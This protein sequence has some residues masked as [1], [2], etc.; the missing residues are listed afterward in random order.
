MKID[1]EMLTQFT[2]KLR[3]KF[4]SGKF[5]VNGTEIKTIHEY[6][7]N[8]FYELFKVFP[9]DSNMKYILQSL[10]NLPGIDH[11]QNWPETKIVKLAKAAIESKEDVGPLPIALDRKKLIILNIL[12]YRPGEEVMFITTGPG[13][14]GKSTFLNLIKQL[15]DNDVSG[16]SLS[17]LGNSFDLAEALHHRLIASDELDS[18]ELDLKV[19]KTIISHQKIQLNPKFERPYTTRAQSQL[20]YCCN[21]VPRIDI[22]D[23]GILRRI[24]YYEMPVVIKNPNTS[25]NHQVFTDE[26]LLAV[27]VAAYNV[28]MTNWKKEFEKETFEYL[29]KNNSVQIWKNNT[30]IIVW[31]E[32]F[33]TNYYQNYKE[34][35]F[36]CGFKAYNI[37]N[38]ADMLDWI[39]EHNVK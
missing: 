5:F 35:C 10:Q 11:Y 16:A 18:G 12:L 29:T 2:L 8:H 24:I 3:I 1:N 36:R 28:D 30:E 7:T 25:L 31:E 6:I 27:A 20:F 26:E 34:F 14:S 9:T 23:T 38:F 4:I 17:T 33:Y 19:L 22:S 32:R 15:F 21:K 13:G 39:L 37:S